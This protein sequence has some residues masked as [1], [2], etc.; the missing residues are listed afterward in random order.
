MGKVRKRRN[1][2]TPAL[3]HRMGEGDPLPRWAGVGAALLAHVNG[4][5]AVKGWA[6]SRG[7]LNPGAMS[8]KGSVTAL[9]PGSAR[10]RSPWPQNTLTEARGAHVP[11][12][13]LICQIG[14]G[15][16]GE[17]WLARNTFGTPRAVKL[18]DR[19]NFSEGYPFEREFK[20]IQKY[21]PVSRGHEGLIDILQI[22]RD[23]EAG[24]FY[25]VMEL[26]DNARPSGNWNIQ[27]LQP[28]VRNGALAL[29][30]PAPYVPKTLREELRQRGRLPADQWLSVSLRLTAAIEHLHE[31]GLVHR[32]IKPSNIIFVDNP[33][34][35]T[36]G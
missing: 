24:Y 26:A 11:D 2:L 4:V 8:N 19:R 25:F 10:S 35:R 21:E 32:D 18:V 13:E 31:S 5:V 30:Q 22:G 6:Y 7:V 23:D 17:V 12:H 15:A 14:N 1:S 36:S 20:G 33:N 28:T 34:S 16:Y 9:H 3:S 29:K 27:L